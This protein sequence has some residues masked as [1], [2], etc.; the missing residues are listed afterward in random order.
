M[1]TIPPKLLTK[2]S[3]TPVKLRNREKPWY[4]IL[5]AC[6]YPTTAVVL[7]FETYADSRYS[8]SKM[9]TA[10]YIMDSRFEV[11][12]LGVLEMQT[13]IDEYKTRTLFVQQE[14]G[15]RDRIARLQQHYGSDLS[16]CVVIMKNAKFD[17]LVLALRYH[18]YPRYIIDI[19]DL[20][21]HYRTRRK[22]DLKHLAN[23]YGLP[24]K[25]DT[26]V[27]FG[28]SFKPR[29]VR[30]KRGKAPMRI[31]VMATD[32]QT[33]LAEY[34][35]NDVMRE[36]ELFI[37][38]LPFLSNPNIELLAMQHTLELF[39]KPSLCFD[40]ARAQQLKETM[41]LE[42]KKACEAANSSCTDISGSKSFMQKLVSALR[43]AS[44]D[45]SLYL[46]PVK[47]GGVKIAE[48]KLDAEREQLLT[49]PDPTV[50]SLMEARVAVKSWPLHTKRI[51]RLVRTTQA[52]SGLL[53]V[54]LIYYGCHTGRW[55][56]GE[57][58][59]LQN[60][61]A[62]SHEL[63]NA[64]REL[65]V[66]P[67][68]HKLV[69]VDS[70]QIEARV[71]AWLAGQADL[72]EK[73]RNNEEI[74]CG[75][76]TK[77]LGWPVRKPKATGIPEIEA[78]HR[79]ARQYIGKTGILGCGYGMGASKMLSQYKGGLTADV[80]EKIVQTY[81]RE[82]PAITQFWY[83]VE[84][85]FAETVQTEKARTFGKLTLEAT[86]KSDVVITLPNGR[87]LSYHDVMF[88]PAIGR[89]DMEVYNALKKKWERIWGGHLTENIVQ[90]ISRDILLEAL[91]KIESEG[92]H[93]AHHVHDE[94]IIVVPDASAQKALE[95]A[96]H[97][98]S[99]PPAWGLD[100]PLAAEGAITDR[101][102]GH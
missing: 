46:K 11:L 10:E 29:W 22:H 14:Q 89:R 8:L 63:I 34:C 12:G 26:K 16:Q 86:Q 43:D 76:A 78:R 30:G 54:P 96:I 99:V 47:G 87:E 28:C 72:V 79:W 90:A 51:E 40:I 31:P 3:V 83:G 56:G 37:I 100:L 5:Q 80:A 35:R 32:Q 66:A 65:I 81:R 20:S 84:L 36:W 21:R 102:G 92:F 4:E 42:V 50:R 58:L 82:H 68:D 33:A 53:P 18:I 85:V 91:L 41:K 64:I 93:V 101:Y 77:V 19:D 49:H 55:S 62:R 15:V 57:K 97:L 73:F 98:L 48:A 94:L 67:P 44:D 2:S 17:A 25:G 27:F 71:L 9:A 6:H 24:P 61:G 23:E 74:Y 88:S 7:D 60:L 52:C 75:F 38:L 69:I 70:S 1:L 59:N 45:P 95:R 39:T 13:P